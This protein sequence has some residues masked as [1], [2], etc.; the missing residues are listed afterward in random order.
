[1]ATE[2]LWRCQKPESRRI[3]LRSS[4]IPTVSREPHSGRLQ[5]L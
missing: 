4:R 3:N 5:D 2:T 1:M